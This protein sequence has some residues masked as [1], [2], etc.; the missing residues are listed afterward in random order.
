MNECAPDTAMGFPSREAF[1]LH[2]RQ[3]GEDALPAFVFDGGRT[4]DGPGLY[5]LRPLSRLG[6]GSEKRGLPCGGKLH[7]LRAALQGAALGPGE[8]VAQPAE[9]GR[10][11]QLLGGAG[12]PIAPMGGTAHEPLH[13]DERTLPGSRGG[14]G[15]TTT[16]SMG[17]NVQNARHPAAVEGVVPDKSR[18]IRL[19]Q[20]T[21]GGGGEAPR[22]LARGVVAALPP[23]ADELEVQLLTS[24]RGIEHPGLAA[25]R[26]LPQLEISV[27]ASEVLDLDA[28]HKAVRRLLAG[29]GKMH[30]FKI[31]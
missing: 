15:P 19:G 6:Q 10:D 31:T 18:E 20:Q 27:C 7:G 30:L 2:R 4:A 9:D 17:Q 29:H 21:V 28:E 11:I 26:L 25:D 14:D 13:R 23:F 3:H 24:H 1:L 16:G 22:Q 5:R 8:V 12:A